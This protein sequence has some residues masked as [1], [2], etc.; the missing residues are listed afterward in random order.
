VKEGADVAV[1]YNHRSVAEQNSIDI[2]WNILVDDRY[3]DLRDCIFDS[4]SECRRFRQLVVNSV[5]ATDIFDKELN[6]HRFE[7]WNKSFGHQRSGVLSLDAF[8]IH[9]KATV[10]IEHIIQA[11]DIAHTMQHWHVYTKWMQ[12]FFFETYDAYLAGRGGN[13]PSVEWYENELVF[14]DQ[15]VIP[16]AKKLQSCGVFGVASDEYLSYALNNREEWQRKG[17]EVVKQMLMAY[18]ELQSSTDDKI[19]LV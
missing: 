2:A 15:Y 5:I 12:K 8:E 14:F 16:L 19:C 13:D 1:K 18:G 4:E 17:R 7:R 3:Q 10:V 9:R 11:S 6:A